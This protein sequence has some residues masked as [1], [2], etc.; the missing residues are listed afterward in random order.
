MEEIIARLKTRRPTR[1]RIML[2]REN[3]TVWSGLR[4]GV[5]MNLPSYTR[6]ATGSDLFGAATAIL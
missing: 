6:P 3:G 5:A 1:R 2:R 4:Q